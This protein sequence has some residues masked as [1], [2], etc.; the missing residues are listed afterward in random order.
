MGLSIRAMFE[1]MLHRPLLVFLT[2]AVITAL[3]GWQLPNLSFK[4]SVY[5]LQIEDLPETARYNDFKKLFGSDEIIRVVIKSGIVFDPVTFRKIELLGE[6]AAKIE[7]VRRV[8]S[9]PGIKKAV[10]VSGNWSMDK[11]YAVVSKAE[12]FRKNLISTDGQTTALTLVLKNGADSQRVVRQVRQMLEAAPVDLKLY[13]IGMPLVSEALARFTEKDFFR[14][15]PI[16]FLI[17]A[18]IL[19]Y[20]FRKLQ[21][22]LI[23]LACVGLSLVWTLGLMAFLSIPLSMLTMIV[24]VFLVAVGT[25]YCLHIVSEYLASIK[26]ADSPFDATRKTFASISLPTLLAVLT[27]VVGLGS[28]LA[29]RITAIREFAVFS[30]FGM[31]SILIIVL[32]FLPAVLSILPLSAKRAVRQSDPNPF[33]TSIID[34]I[35]DLNLKHQKIVLPII[36]AVVLLCLIGIFRIQ[37]ETNPVGYLKNDAPVKR[38][39]IDIYQDLSGSFPINIAMGGS[40]ADFFEDPGNLADIVRLQE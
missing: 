16:T 24:P 30:C 1:W 17:I 12:L 35:V 11:Y 33:F 26:D 25:A 38:N 20:L 29:N 34:K 3:F 28:L 40:A 21:Y 2:T 36:G 5:D 13:Q 18:V 27:T 22:I 32:T 31:V 19:F 37:V 39:F 14:L 8:I 10:D 7:G 6:A 15:P 23:P 9:L 4:T